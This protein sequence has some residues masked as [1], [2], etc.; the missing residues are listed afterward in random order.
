MNFKILILF[1]SLLISSPLFALNT[2]AEP[3]LMRIVCEEVGP[4]GKKLDHIL[5]I[6][7][8][9]NDVMNGDELLKS[10]SKGHKSKK[11]NLS[12]KIVKATLDKNSDSDLNSNVN[13]ILSDDEKRA[14]YKNT[15][16][17]GEGDIFADTFAFVHKGTDTVKFTLDFR[18]LHRGSYHFNS[19]AR[20]TAF[21]CKKPYTIP[22]PKAPATEEQ[23]Y[24]IGEPTDIIN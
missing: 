5:V 1:N 17:L 12:L 23:I 24:D 16:V 18:L 20:T 21:S 15:E 3:N 8:T 22:V 19:R 11:V 14:D 13:K 9:S 6:D 2:V 7:Q 4:T 10:G